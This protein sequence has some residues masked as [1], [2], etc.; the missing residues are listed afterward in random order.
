VEHNVD[1]LEKD[2]LIESREK[3]TRKAEKRKAEKSREKRR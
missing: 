3:R 1:N 2:V